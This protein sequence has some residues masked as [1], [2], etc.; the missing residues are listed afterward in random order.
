MCHPSLPRIVRTTIDGNIALGHNGYV[1]LEFRAQDLVIKYFD[2]SFVDA[3]GAR[4]PIVEEHWA[5][6]TTTGALTG[7][8]ITPFAAD[9]SFLQDI[10]TAYLSAGA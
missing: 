6:D 7:K 1:I 8:G 10:E 4:S 3:H 9:L 2:D 5:V